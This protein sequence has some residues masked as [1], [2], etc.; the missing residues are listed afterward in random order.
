MIYTTIFD[1]ILI[2][3]STY[4]SAYIIYAPQ[5]FYLILGLDA[6]AIATTALFF[7]V[8]RTAGWLLVPYLAWLGYASYLNGALLRLNPDNK[9]DGWTV[10][11]GG[12]K[13]A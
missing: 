12:E 3:I 4:H 5:S 11:A 8:D 10:A 7:K 2:Q 9:A 6:L 13:L 1:T